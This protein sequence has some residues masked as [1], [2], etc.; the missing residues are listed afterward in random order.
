ML[1]PA[2][3]MGTEEYY[4]FIDPNNEDISLSDKSTLNGKKIGVNRD[5]IQAEFFKKWA[6]ENN[7]KSKIV[8]VSCSEDE[9]LHM[10]NSGELDAY[11]T[12]DSFMDTTKAQPTYMVGSSDFYFAVSKK[13]PDLLEDLE[14]AMNRIQKENRYYNVQMYEKFIKKTGA[15]ATLGSEEKEWLSKHKKIKVGYQ[16]NYLA[17]CAQDEKTG[18]LTGVMKDYLD[19][20]SKCIHGTHIEFETIAYPTA[21]DALDALKKGEIDC[22]FPSNL[23]GYDAEKQGTVMTPALFETE[24]Y[25]VVRTKSAKIFSNEGQIIVAVN[26]GNINYQAF[27][28]KHY[29]SWQKAY[30]SSTEDCLKAVSK[31]VADCLIISNYR[32]NNI[33]KFC[34][35]Y[36]LTTY[37]TGLEMDYCFAVKEGNTELYSIL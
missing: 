6:D 10:L 11:G 16:D 1:Y 32:I 35:R 28:S 18:E 20:A 3:P 37:S 9:S 15:S 29:P 2:L 7:V 23:G 17:F 25:A 30:F 36:N 24:M 22:A 33:S 14:Y 5:S 34:S 19:I 13:R 8:L 26:S 12:V 31:G 21:K 27:L 4:I